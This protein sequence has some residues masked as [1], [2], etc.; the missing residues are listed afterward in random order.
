M[1]KKSLPFINLKFQQIE[2]GIILRSKKNIGNISKPLLS[3]GNIGIYNE[4]ICIDTYYNDSGMEINIEL[5]YGIPDMEDI[6]NGTFRVNCFF[7]IENNKLIIASD[8]NI[9][10]DQYA[11]R[12]AIMIE[13][14]KYELLNND[15]KNIRI[16][17]SSIK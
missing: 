2:N 6:D 14:N 7:N 4:M 11:K 10:I 3:V 9:D 15:V 1:T 17:T 12:I 5:I 16:Y 13:I 8:S